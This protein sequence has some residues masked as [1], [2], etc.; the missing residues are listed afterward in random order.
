MLNNAENNTWNIHGAGA[1]T[2]YRNGVSE[3]F[4]AGTTFS[5]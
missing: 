5:L 1:V 3:S 2:L 4:S